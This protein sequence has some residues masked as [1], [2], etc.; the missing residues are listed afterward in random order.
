M[1]VSAHL[2]S[3]H[4]PLQRRLVDHY[5][6][7][8][9]EVARVVR[10]TPVDVR[11]ARSRGVLDLVQVLVAACAAPASH[12]ACLLERQRVGQ[13]I[14]PELFWCTRTDLRPLRGTARSAALPRCVR[15]SPK[16]S[17]S[18]NSSISGCARVCRQRA[19]SPPPW[20][21]SA[22]SLRCLVA[23]SEQGI[24]RKGRRSPGCSEKTPF[25]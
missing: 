13:V 10:S 24:G 21:A 9:H 17:L 23:E 1:D 16:T 25:R 5:V 18:R 2:L 11:N 3:V 20:P 7:P 14:K 4:P 6:T 8:R 12:H 22:G 15:L 19:A